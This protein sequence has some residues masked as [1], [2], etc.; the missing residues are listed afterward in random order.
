[1]EGRLSNINSEHVQFLD[2]WPLHDSYGL[3]LNKK[4]VFAKFNAMNGEVLP[5]KVRESDLAI[6]LLMS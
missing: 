3:S 2:Q 6:P 4:I 1:M 5:R